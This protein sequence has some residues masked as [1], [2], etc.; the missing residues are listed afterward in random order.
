MIFS[1]S[2][3]KFHCEN[4]AFVNGIILGDSG[5]EITNYL[6]IPIQNPTTPAQSLYNESQI[7]SRN[8]IERCFGVWKRRF[9]VLCIGLRCK[10]P[11][12]QDVI[13]ACAVLHNL[14]RTKNEE[15]PQ[16][17]PEVHVPPQPVFPSSEPRPPVADE[18]HQTRH[19]MLSYF[20]ALIV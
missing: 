14:A 1:N 6:L 20:Q 16:E 5:Y 18:R 15:E 4:H 9:P 7:R 2:H 17:D 12:A 19:I 8:V 11:L 10:L 3:V 13:V